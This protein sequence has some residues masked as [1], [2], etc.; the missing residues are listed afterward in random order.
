MVAYSFRARFV[1]PIEAG[2]KRQTIR[3]PRK[4]HAK[5]GEELQLYTGMRTRACRLIR[6]ATCRTVWPISLS[7]PRAGLGEIILGERFIN[8][9]SNLDAFA[10][11]DGFEDWWQMR[12][13]WR[14]AHGRDLPDPWSGVMIRW[15]PIDG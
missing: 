2:T 13:F 11:A 5:P 14:D 10:R 1:A 15:E 8:D 12:E 9:P 6:L 4:R 3:A 7:M